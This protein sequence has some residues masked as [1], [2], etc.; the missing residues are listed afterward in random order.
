M[1]REAFVYDQQK[2]AKS[3]QTDMPLTCQFQ[4]TDWQILMKNPTS[5]QFVEYHK[6]KR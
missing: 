6:S 5:T 4:T 1:F 3:I 2:L